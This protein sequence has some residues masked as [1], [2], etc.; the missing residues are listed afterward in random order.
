M[1]ERHT[2]LFCVDDTLHLPEKVFVCRDGDELRRLVRFLSGSPPCSLYLSLH[3]PQQTAKPPQPF[4]PSDRMQGQFI[5]LDFLC[6]VRR[7]IDLVS[8][9]QFPHLCPCSIFLLL[10]QVFFVLTIYGNVIFGCGC[11][12][13]LYFLLHFWLS[14]RVTPCFYLFFYLLSRSL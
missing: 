13:F 2:P 14:A 6:S 1:S 3:S 7:L 12:F 4:R 5:S 10:P 11:F 8:P 9:F